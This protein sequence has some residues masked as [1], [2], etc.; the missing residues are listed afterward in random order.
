ARGEGLISDAT[1]SHTQMGRRRR[2]SVVTHVYHTVDVGHVFRAHV[3]HRH[4][5]I[6]LLLAGRRSRRATGRHSDPSRVSTGA[7]ADRAAT[8]PHA[9]ASSDSSRATLACDCRP[10]PRGSGECPA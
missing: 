8:L 10:R 5:V 4:L 9:P 1:D 3:A 7:K 6:G 2:Y